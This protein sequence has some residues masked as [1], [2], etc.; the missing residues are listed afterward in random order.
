M[1]ILLLE[2]KRVIKSRMTWIL[3]LVAIALSGIISYQVI[4]KECYT[5]FDKNGHA[6]NITGIEAIRANKKQS[7]PYDGMITEKKLKNA[8]LMYQEFDRDS[9]KNIPTDRYTA[10]SEKVPN[11]FFMLDMIGLV[12]PGKGDHFEDL[13]NLDPKCIDTFYQR[14]TK[15]LTEQIKAQYPGNQ[16][17]LRQ[18]QELNSRVKKPFFYNSGYVSVNTVFLCSLIFILVLIAAMIVSPVFSADYQNGSDD[19]LRCTKNGHMKLAVAKLS[20]AVFILLAMFAICILTFVLTVNSAFGWNSLQSSYQATCVLSF[21][22][23]TMGQTQ[24]LTILAGLLI[25]LAMA[26]FVLFVSAKCQHPTTALII[27]VAF[28]ILPE[29]L[30][31]IWNGNVV[32]FLTCVLPAGSA[33]S[34]NFYTQLNQTTFFHLGSLDIGA[35][36]IIIG[37][38]IIEIPL[39][40]ILAIRAYCKHRAA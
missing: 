11:T 15:I 9:R 24:G 2:M 30:H 17:I 33:G 39:F 1:H 16:N 3:L 23:L 37:A 31:A 12:Y 29:I 36:Y 4:A 6:I 18:V 7:Q 8:L 22:P 28:C 5:K 26:C 27:A 10:L 19:I 40:F 14:R 32:N 25:L 20:S 21:V 35:P 13:K 34:H 38:A